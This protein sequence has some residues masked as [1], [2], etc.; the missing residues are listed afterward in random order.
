MPTVL[1]MCRA[2]F[3][4][5]LSASGTRW[6]LPDTGSGGWE[7]NLKADFPGADVHVFTS[8]LSRAQSPERDNW[9]WA[10]IPKL[11]RKLKEELENKE[12]SNQV[13]QKPL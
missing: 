3:V 5:G 13:R 9:P 12:D 2:I 7:T 10:T 6:P 1:T 8:H 4:S 11:A